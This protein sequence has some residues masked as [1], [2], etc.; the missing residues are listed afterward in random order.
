LLHYPGPFR[1]V[2][3]EANVREL[4]AFSTKLGQD[5]LQIS[6]GQ[7]AVLSL[8]PRVKQTT[9]LKDLTDKPFV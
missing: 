5:A 3:L 7:I 4:F 8:G 9:C 6:I 1:A 2:A